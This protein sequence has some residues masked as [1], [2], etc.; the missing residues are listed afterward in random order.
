MFAELL[1]T[2]LLLL[3]LA[4]LVAGVVRGFAGFGTGMIAGPVAAALY[5]P[6][7]GL[8]LL[9]VIDTWPMLPLLPAAWRKANFGEIV[10][11]LAGYA[12]LVP[13][14]LWFLKTGDQTLLRWFISLAVLSLVAVLASGWRYEGSRT[15]PVSLG[16]GAVSGFLG[17]SIGVNGPPVILYWM[18][19][20]TGAGF[21]RANILVFFAFT[22]VIGG[23]GLWFA[24]L[25]TAKALILGAIASPVYLI[26]LLAGARMFGLAS[27]EPCRR[28]AFA[29]ILTAAIVSMPLLD[30]VLR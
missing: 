21:V 2:D 17:G 30:G 3:S 22:N 13:L 16:V 10:P 26:G 14:G 7:V 12:C 25:W 1:D 27:E 8:P 5:G 28:I 11:L 29:V 18:A 9:F 24:G 4:V 20:R 23:V 19:L 6:Q 15:R